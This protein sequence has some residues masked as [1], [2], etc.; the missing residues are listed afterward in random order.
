[1]GTAAAVAVAIV[2][3]IV[4]LLARLVSL[5][6]AVVIGPAVA[7]AAV[8]LVVARGNA[9]LARRLRGIDRRARVRQRK[10]RR[11][12]RQV[13]D[14]ESGRLFRQLEAL[15][16]V[17]DAL[18]GQVPLPATRGWA[19]SP[20]MLR[21]LVTI[22]LARR[23]KV[24][25]EMG[26]GVSTLAVAACLRRLGGGHLWS[27]EHVPGFA[28]EIRERLASQGLDRWAT[29]VDAPLVDVRLGDETWRWYDLAGLTADLPIEVV[30]V[31]GPPSTTGPLA[32]YPAVPVLLPRLAPGAAILVDDV[33]RADD[34]AVVNRWR[35]EVPQLEGRSL[36]LE[37]GAS[38][39]T[40]AEPVRTA[41]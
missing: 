34:R 27:L 9:R 25:V 23:P 7:T 20:D 36:G 1:V 4:M 33:G 6:L 5:D 37:K 30:F 16:A 8:A 40:L 11:Y 15:D 2:V 32:R 22:V 41:G 17:R 26:S 18:G 28:A 31:D 19:A 13:A 12:T 35:S 10:M 39:L 38:L 24:V 3:I 21:E 14:R 29:V